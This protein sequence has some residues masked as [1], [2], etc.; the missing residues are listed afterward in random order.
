MKNVKGLVL[1]AAL[2]AAGSVFA[3]ARVGNVIDVSTYKTNTDIDL[4]RSVDTN[5]WENGSAY[6]TKNEKVSEV[7]TSDVDGVSTVK[8]V[9]IEISTGSNSTFKSDTYS[10][11]TLSLSEH[12]NAKGIRQELEAFGSY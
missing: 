3:E 4:N 1:V 10:S 5:M 12:S 8:N 2:T 6:A 11:E 7:I 9:D